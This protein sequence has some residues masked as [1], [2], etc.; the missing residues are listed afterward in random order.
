M[1]KLVLSNIENVVNKIKTRS[2]EAGY[3]NFKEYCVDGF[4]LLAFTKLNVNNENFFKLTNGDFI[5]TSGTL[6]YKEQLGKKAL[7]L[8]Y[9]N[10]HGKLKDVREYIVGNYLLTIK[11]NDKIY[12]FCEENN[13][14]NIFYRYNN[15]KWIVSNSFN[16]VAMYNTKELTINNFNFLEYSFQS[17]IIG[18]GTVYNEIYKL[19]GDEYVVIDLKE[20][21]FKV[22]NEEIDS[23]VSSDIDTNSIDYFCEVLNDKVRIISEKFKNHTMCMT[24]GLDSR[25]VFSSMMKNNIKPNLTYGI[26]NSPLTNTKSKDLSINRIIAERYALDLS[27]MNWDTPEEF[28]RDW[29][30]L[31]D[32]YDILSLIYAGSKN[33]F[34]ALEN[35]KTEFID[36]GYFGEPYR[37]VPWIDQ[38]KSDTFTINEFIDDFYIYKPLKTSITN[39]TQYRNHLKDKFLYLCEMKNLNPNKLTK[40]D[41]QVL[42]NVYRKGADTML[43]N[44]MNR[45]CYS[46][47]ILGQKELLDISEILPYSIKKDSNFILKAINNNY[48]DTLEIPFFSHIENWI[49]DS[50]SFKLIP[51]NKEKL[52]SKF[53]KAKFKKI[54]TNDKLISWAKMIYIKSCSGKYSQKD[55]EEYSLSRILEEDII[56]V[57]KENPYNIIDGELKGKDIRSLV[58]YGQLLEL[59]RIL[60]K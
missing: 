60:K 53:L 15:N 34:G 29:L 51:F 20:D 11:K 59:F 1:S 25:L 35:I 27:V 28:N 54:I 56:N 16:D 44:L 3:S 9:E 22:R 17:T 14:F 46:V 36:F 31:N 49:F 7:R 18:N 33:V 6:I 32:K 40:I 57:I 2:I 45:L 41:F 10:F 42:H 26:G 58:K 13:L 5:A 47:S 30:E 55:V 12:I 24:G 48:C 38:L 39:Y 8:L 37:N 23:L 4:N 43:L 19:L 50:E 21:S 52:V